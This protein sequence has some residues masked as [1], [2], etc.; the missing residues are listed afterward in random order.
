MEIRRKRAML[1]NVQ[2]QEFVSCRMTATVAV[3]GMKSMVTT[4]KDR[5]EAVEKLEVSCSA[6][7]A[8]GLL[9]N[10]TPSV[11]MAFSLAGKLLISATVKRQSKPIKRPTGSTSLPNCTR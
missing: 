7:P 9:P 1:K 2:P 5:P 6:S 4:R 3:H 8:L 10:R 11:A